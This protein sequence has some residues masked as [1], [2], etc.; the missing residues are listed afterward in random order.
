M[1]ISFVI[2]CYYSQDTIR[3]EV[4]AVIEQFEMHEGYEYEFYDRSI[5]TTAREFNGKTRVYAALQNCHQ[6]A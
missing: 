2:P 4:E 1:L 3:N 6:N 5:S